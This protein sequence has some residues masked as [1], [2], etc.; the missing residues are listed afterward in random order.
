MLGESYHYTTR[1]LTKVNKLRVGKIT[2]WEEHMV[3]AAM[4]KIIIKRHHCKG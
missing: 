3:H 1:Y 2:K 4:S